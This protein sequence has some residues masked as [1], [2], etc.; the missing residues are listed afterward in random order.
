MPAFHFSE[1]FVLFSA[2]V[3]FFHGVFVLFFLKLFCIIFSISVVFHMWIAFS[4]GLKSFLLII[5]S[6]ISLSF[7]LGTKFCLVKT[8]NSL[9]DIVSFT[10]CFSVFFVFTFVT[11]AFRFFAHFSVLSNHFF[12][13]S[14]AF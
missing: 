14:V 13:A 5:F 3:S 4:L 12:V 7:S 9:S 2:F 6:A 11:L 1:F 10:A 8:S